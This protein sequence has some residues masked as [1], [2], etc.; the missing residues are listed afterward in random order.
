MQSEKERDKTNK[1]RTKIESAVKVMVEEQT[2]IENLQKN[3]RARREKLESESEVLAG[4]EVQ[5]FIKHE[6]SKDENLKQ[7]SEHINL[8]E[9]AL[10][11]ER[12]KELM[13]AIFTNRISSTQ[14][15]VRASVMKASQDVGYAITLGPKGFGYREN[16]QATPIF[17]MYIFK[18][19]IL[20]HYDIIVSAMESHKSRIVRTVKDDFVKFVELVNF[21]ES[22]KKELVITDEVGR[23]GVEVKLTN[24]KPVMHEYREI[25]FKPITAMISSHSCEFLS[26]RNAHDSNSRIRSELY[27]TGS[28]GRWAIQTYFAMKDTTLPEIATKLGELVEKL[29]ESE[30][31]LKQKL[32]HFNKHVLAISI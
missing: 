27:F 31:Q 23:M 14:V 8:M 4:D 26:E 29:N 21:I 7:I 15:L 12:L 28:G 17:S 30:E 19:Y 16:V 10:G 32:R 2:I 1:L 5:T 13:C 3:L 11:E 20:K 6:K 24:A 22:V 18:K 25:V 9:K